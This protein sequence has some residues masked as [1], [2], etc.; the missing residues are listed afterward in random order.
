MTA[1]P[2]SAKPCCA[3]SAA[4]TAGSSPSTT[5]DVPLDDLR[6]L[7]IATATYLKLGYHGFKVRP[8]APRL[9]VR[10][11]DY[12][13]FLHVQRTWE[14]ERPSDLE[15]LFAELSRIRTGSPL[16]SDAYVLEARLA[17]R[18]FFDTRDPGDLDRSLGLIAQ[19]RALAPGDPLPLSATLVGIALPAGP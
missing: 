8:E 10:A 15:P 1:R 13:R 16:F 2:A 3:A 6:L 12:E 5:F 19:A 4:A 18:R 14:E 11:E 17:G 7:D 9:Q